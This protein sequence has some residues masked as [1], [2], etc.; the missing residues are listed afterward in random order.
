[1]D[2][3][4]EA[5]RRDP[6]TVAHLGIGEVA[7]HYDAIVR[8]LDEPPIIIGHS[9]GGLIAQILLDRG[10][11]A[12]G[13]AIDSAPVKGI[14]RLPWSE[15]RSSFPALKNPANNHRAVA[16]TPDEFHYA[17]ANTVDPAESE[18]IYRRY[19][20][21]G[22]GRVLF[23]AA[24]ANFTPNAPSTIDFE[25]DTRAPLLLVAGA[26]DHVVPPSV[27]VANAKLQHRSKSLTA[28]KEFP[29]RPH[30]LLGL[31]GWE[32][33]ADFVLEWALA[34]TSLG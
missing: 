14:F 1:M 33:V 29:G 32:E 30:F 15:L 18:R 11:G 34:P 22:P 28:F 13:V 16:L 4:I 24:L 27:T 6:S 20:V 23:Q 25:N 21:P 17:F 8:D 7:A 31:S 19:A 12:A 9:F 10:L 5:L 2:V 3:D 26:R